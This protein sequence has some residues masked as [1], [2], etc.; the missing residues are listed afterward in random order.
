MERE[1]VN[2]WESR[3][4]KHWIELHRNKWGYSYRAP[5]MGG[6]LGDMSRLD[7]LNYMLDR[8]IPSAQ[9]DANKTDMKMV[10][11]RA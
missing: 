2:R 4:G 11:S 10:L 9:P 5:S 1:P 6:S 7:A 8:V 3:S